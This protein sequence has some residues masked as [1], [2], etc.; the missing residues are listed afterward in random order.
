MTTPLLAGPFWV[1]PPLPV[2]TPFPVP[3][4][5]VV[6]SY[7]MPRPP[8]FPVRRG[9]APAEG[10]ARWPVQTGPTEGVGRSR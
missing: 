3:G 5:F 4:P 8:G 7:S 9:A 1:L 2:V 6:L 10:A